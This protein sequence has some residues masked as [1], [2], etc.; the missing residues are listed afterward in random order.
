MKKLQ[1]TLCKYSNGANRSERGSVIPKMR[2]RTLFVKGTD[3][4]CPNENYGI[5][6]VKILLAFYT[7][8]SNP[9]QQPELPGKEI[10][11]M[12]SRIWPFDSK[13]GVTD[14]SQTKIS[15]LTTRLHYFL[16]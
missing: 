3:A 10:G 4:R 13:I 6:S 2:H 15:A 9:T 11:K 7:R 1:R 8:Q 12:R 14:S 5:T 16:R